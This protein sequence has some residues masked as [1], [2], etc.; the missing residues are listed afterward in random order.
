MFHTLGAVKN[1]IGIGMTEPEIR[2]AVEKKIVRT[3]HRIL[4]PTQHER[5]RLMRYYGASVEKIGVVPCG[6]N[7]DFFF[8]IEQ[9][10]ARNKLGFDP[11]D[12]ILLYV[13]RFE[14]MKGLNRLLEA[15]AYLDHR[16]RLRLLVIG[17]DGN[18]DPESRPFDSI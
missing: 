8:P 18:I 9:M 17:G 4:A 3:C 14:P 2:I 16:P 13:G 5:E 15:M 1:S 6:V 7:L 12:T 11:D 10:T